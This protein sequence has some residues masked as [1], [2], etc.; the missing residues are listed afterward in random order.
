MQR[1][2]TGVV[3]LQE[4]VEAQDVE[5]QLPVPKGMGIYKTHSTL[6]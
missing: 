2:K 5:S 4:R 3:W 6:D 1:C